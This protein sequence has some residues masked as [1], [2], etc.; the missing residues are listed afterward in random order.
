MDEQDILNIPEQE[1]ANVFKTTYDQEL[2]ENNS[3]NDYFELVI[4]DCKDRCMGYLRSKNF[5]SLSDDELKDIFADSIII[6]LEKIRKGGLVLTVPLQ[7]YLIG[8]CRIKLL[9]I[10]NANNTI[11]RDQEIENYSEDGEDFDIENSENA[12]DFEEIGENLLYAFEDESEIKKDFLEKSIIKMTQLLEKIRKDGGNCYELITLFSYEKL[13]IANLTARF[14]YANDAVT[15]S[16][17]YKCLKKI[18]SLWQQIN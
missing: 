5:I 16:L 15:K 9:Q 17:R 10:V 18:R 12:Y 4:R 8:V 6:L 1:N 2:F 3:E 7:I 13:Q 14:E 11:N